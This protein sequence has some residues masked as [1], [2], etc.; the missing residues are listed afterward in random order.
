MKVKCEIILS[1]DS[2][3]I[4]FQLSPLPVSVRHDAR[5]DTNRLIAV[6][7]VT[8]SSQTYTVCFKS[9]A[10]T[11]S[12]GLTALYALYTSVRCGKLENT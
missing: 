3:I 10:V 11:V 4:I 1:N 12:E 5:I 7:I 2:I 8:V 9:I 6:S